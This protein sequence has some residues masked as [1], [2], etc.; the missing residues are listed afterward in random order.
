LRRVLTG[1][2]TAF[3]VLSTLQQASASAPAPCETKGAQLQASSSATLPNVP[4]PMGAT[5]L[6]V[7]RWVTIKAGRVNVRQGPDLKQDIL[8]TYVKPGTPVEIIA[9]TE[10]WRQIMDVD[11]SKGWVKAGLLD[12]RRNVLVTGALNAPLLSEPR[13]DAQTLAYAAPGLVAR[14]VSCTGRWCSVA[15]RGYE[16]YVERSRLWGVH[17]DERVN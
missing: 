6:P 13:E 14:L 9:E 8:W 11:C 7:P 17:P 16:G 5:G 10:G 2:V 12:G 15:S 3:A 1:L 4:P